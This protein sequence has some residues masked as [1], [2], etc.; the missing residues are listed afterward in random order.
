MLKSQTYAEIPNILLKFYTAKCGSNLELSAEKY[1]CRNM[2]G[3]GYGRNLVLELNLFAEIP[4]PES[5]TYAKTYA[6]IPNIFY[7]AKCITADFSDQ[8]R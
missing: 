1:T 3:F 8:F 6:K 2:F 4:M 5:Q 7:T